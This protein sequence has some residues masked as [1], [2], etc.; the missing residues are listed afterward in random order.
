MVA[1]VKNDE[2]K[3][4]M[5]EGQQV[6]SIAR[7]YVIQ[8]KGWDPDDVQ[9]KYQGSRNGTQEESVFIIHPE[10]VLAGLQ[11]SRPARLEEFIIDLLQGAVITEQELQIPDKAQWALAIARDFIACEKGL[12][13]ADFEFEYE[14]ETQ[15]PDLV[16]VFAIDKEDDQEDEQSLTVGAGTGQSRELV[17]DLWKG[18]VIR[19]LFF[20]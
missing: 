13:L 18:Q 7:D 16:S 17:I 12:C 3:M 5:N 20:Q 19:E 8:Q 14:G 4:A 15:T 6:V 10:E 9:I 2:E 11:S 1:C